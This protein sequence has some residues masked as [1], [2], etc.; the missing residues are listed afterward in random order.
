MLPSIENG[1]DLHSHPSP[2][3]HA[4]HGALSFERGLVQAIPIKEQLDALRSWRELLSP[5]FRR[6][7]SAGQLLFQV[8]GVAGYAGYFASMHTF[9]R[10]LS[11]SLMLVT[12]YL[13]YRV[14]GPPQ[15]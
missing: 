11:G 13:I 8:V 5:R 2:A 14:K 4:E 10:L 15:S 1:F 9:L 7:Y 12:W 3:I 6:A